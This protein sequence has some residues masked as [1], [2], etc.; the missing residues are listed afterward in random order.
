[1]IDYL[2]ILTTIIILLI[3][4]KNKKTKIVKEF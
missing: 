2:N 3:I 1:M 4:V